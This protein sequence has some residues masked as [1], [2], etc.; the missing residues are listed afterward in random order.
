MNISINK[1]LETT[2]FSNNL[3][4]SINT[5]LETKIFSNNLQDM[6]P[7]RRNEILTSKADS[8]SCLLK[9]SNR[10]V[11]DLTNLKCKCNPGFKGKNCELETDPCLSNPCLNDGVC[12]Y[13]NSTSLNSEMNTRNYT[14]NCTKLS[15][16]QN[17][18]WKINVCASETCNQHGN[19]IDKSNIPACVCVQGYS[20]EKCEITSQ[21]LI[22]ARTVRKSSA[23]IAILFVVAFVSYILFMDITSSRRKNFGIRS[24]ESKNKIAK[25]NIEKIHLKYT[26]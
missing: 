13:V 20:G 26:P 16:G 6:P 19:C 18:E 23:I 12:H 1:G 3:N 2:S 17:C 25:G 11:C 24:K 8:T 15:Y 5:E 10:G 9:C 21:E 4:S 22:T 14:C 7:E